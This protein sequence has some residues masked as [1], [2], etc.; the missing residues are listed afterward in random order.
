MKSRL[1]YL[2]ISIVISALLLSACAGRNQPGPDQTPEPAE[3]AEPGQ[4]REPAETPDTSPEPSAEPPQDENDADDKKQDDERGAAAELT[5]LLPEREDYEWVYNGFAE[6]GHELELEKIRKEDGKVIYEAEGEVF[7][8]SSGESDR[9]FDIKVNYIV[10]SDSLIQEKKGQM[11][12]DQ[13]DSMVL[14]KLPLEEGN[15]W[16]Q[17]VKGT[18]GEDVELK[19]S[20]EKIEEK[21]GARAYTV[22]Y[23]DQNSPYYEKRVIVEG[24]GV[25]EFTRLYIAE[26]EGDEDFEISYWLYEEASGYKD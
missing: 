17:T 20:I 3:T 9:D 14:L 24:T 13:F 12:M 2:L 6:Y 10:T 11:M 25:T 26:R 4:S 5:A 19:C 8:L 15:S 21:N 7:D 16:T 22:L 18:N 1:A 23:Q